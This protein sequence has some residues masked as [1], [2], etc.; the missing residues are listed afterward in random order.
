MTGATLTEILSEPASH[1][2]VPLESVSSV[3]RATQF[4]TPHELAGNIDLST[5]KNRKGQSGY[6]RCLEISGQG[7][8]EAFIQQRAMMQVRREFPE[9]DAALRADKQN[10][11]DTK[12]GR[13][14]R[15]AMSE[16]LNLGAR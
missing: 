11:L 13:T 2:P 14:P 10:K 16:V 3:G 4:S 12:V 1:H 15:N 9:F 8:R 5:I 6:D 7:L